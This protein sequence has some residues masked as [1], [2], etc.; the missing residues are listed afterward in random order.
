MKDENDS[1]SEGLNRSVENEVIECS[2]VSFF[3][4]TEEIQFTVRRNKPER[5][6]ISLRSRDQRIITKDSND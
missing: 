6:H 4:Q 2:S 1:G 5:V 3:P